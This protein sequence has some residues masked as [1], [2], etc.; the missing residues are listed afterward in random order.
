MGIEGYLAFLALG[1]LAFLALGCLDCL[2]CLVD[3][4]EVDTTGL[5]DS[6]GWLDGSDEGTSLGSVLGWLDGSDEGAL[7]GVWLAASHWN[8]A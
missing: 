3:F 5:V 1:C 6:F 8:R 7:L 2:G 4:C